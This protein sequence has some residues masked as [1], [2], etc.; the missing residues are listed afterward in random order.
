MKD[1]SLDNCTVQWKKLIAI[2][3]TI[4]ALYDTQSF[5]KRQSHSRNLTK[6]KEIKEKKKREK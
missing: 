4:R 6:S 3:K 2:S 5:Q 1:F